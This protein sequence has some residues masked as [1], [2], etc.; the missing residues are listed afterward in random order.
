MSDYRTIDRP[1]ALELLAEAKDKKTLIKISTLDKKIESVTL[2]SQVQPSPKAPLVAVDGS[3]D[4][5][6][7]LEAQ[8][9]TLLHLEFTGRDRLLYAFD[10]PVS[11]SA[12]DGIWLALPEAITRIQRRRNFRLKAPLNT[13]L[14]VG[15]EEEPIHLSVVDYSLGGILGVVASGAPRSSIPPRLAKGRLL[16]HLTLDFDGR[17]DMRVRIRKAVVV[18]VERHPVTGFYQYGV[19]F[20]DIERQEE[21][22]LTEII[23]HMQR[24]Y[25]R[26]RVMM[27]L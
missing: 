27:E 25:L 10:A 19:H 14:K 3:E 2:I 11:R 7:H 9:G 17:P 1:R 21:K 26:Q 8:P 23:Y 12:P 22:R 4:L 5:V 24:Q 15:P 18:R 13:L 6:G 16:E 20:Q